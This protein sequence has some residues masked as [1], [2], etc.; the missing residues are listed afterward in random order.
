MIKNDV[1]VGNQFKS[2]LLCSSL[3][4]LVLNDLKVETSAFKHVAILS[5]KICKIFAGVHWCFACFFWFFPQLWGSISEEKWRSLIFRQNPRF[6]ICGQKGSKIA[7]KWGYWDLWEK[8]CISFVW[9]W[10]KTKEQIKFELLQKTACQKTFFGQDMAKN[11]HF[12]RDKNS[13][14]FSFTWPRDFQNFLFFF[15]SSNLICSFVLSHF[16]KKLIK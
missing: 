12:C 6:S 5:L 2:L 16:Q 7:Q 14:G 9:K 8:C 15:K 11:G 4:F 10:L 1:W 3:S 13:Q